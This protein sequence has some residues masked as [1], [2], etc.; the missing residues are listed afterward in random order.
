MSRLA[1]L[2]HGHIHRLQ[3]S[4]AGIGRHALAH[5]IRTGRLHATTLRGVY[6]VGRPQPDAAGRM[7]AAALYFKGDGLVTSRAAA[8]LWGQL[9]TTQL[10]RD[11]E[12]IGIQL[13]G[14]N[15]EDPPGVR[16]HRTRTVLRQD[17]RWRKG[18]PVTSPALTILR[19]AG[20]IGDL[21]LETV[22]SAGF[23]KNLVRRSQLDDVMRRNPR[24][25]GIATLR[26][27]LEQT[28]SLHD[29]RSSYERKLLRLLRDAELPLPITNTWVGGV[30]V[31]GVWPDLKLV[32]EFDGWQTHGER[33]GFETDRLRDQRL[34]IAGHQTFRVTARQIDRRP[35]ALVARI[36]SIATALR[37]NGAESQAAWASEAIA[38]PAR[39]R[40]PR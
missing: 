31:D 33:A 37:T 35:Y 27:L 14:R 22:L 26:S 34:L 39:S 11:D 12:P 9:D 7:M 36:A 4:A 17:I 30:Y 32:L 2:Q 16:I 5:R 38:T 15:A 40:R 20:Q 25:N 10:L 18:I 3:L 8:Q 6:L 29:T 28:E 13:V 21:E 19:L 1:E 24:A 23:R